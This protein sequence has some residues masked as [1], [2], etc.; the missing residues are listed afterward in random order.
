MTVSASRHSLLKGPLAAEDYMFR[1][2]M[3]RAESKLRHTDVE[4][5]LG[6][7]SKALSE[8]GGWTDDVRIQVG[9]KKPFKA[10]AC[11]R[12]LHGIPSPRLWATKAPSFPVSPAKDL[13]YFFAVDADKRQQLLSEAI[14]HL[15]SPDEFATWLNTFS[16]TRFEN[17]LISAI[18][19]KSN[20]Q[21]LKKLALIGAEIDRLAWFTGQKSM[22]LA[23]AS[24]VWRP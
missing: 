23:N 1:L 16:T 22:T 14:P 8:A 11:V 20:S 6:E 18:V 10:K 2:L 21:P 13:I 7:A 3:G 19:E 9:V 5:L 17:Q 12:M 15:A 4:F 24:P